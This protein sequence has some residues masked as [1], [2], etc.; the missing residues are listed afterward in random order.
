MDSSC[1]PNATKSVHDIN[2]NTFIINLQQFDFFRSINN[3]PGREQRSRDHCSR[4]K[5]QLQRRFSN[6]AKG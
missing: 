2:H 1:V 3:E 4:Q 5:A 6:D